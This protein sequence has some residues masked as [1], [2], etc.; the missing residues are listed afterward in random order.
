[1][2]YTPPA[3]HETDPEALRRFLEA[4]P[5]G[6]L[7]TGPPLWAT[8]LPLE[9]DFDA[10]HRPAAAWLHLAAANPQ[11]QALETAA[12]ALVVVLGPH[13]YISPTWYGHPNVP[14]WNYLAAHIS[15][16]IRPVT[17][18]DE[19]RQRLDALVAQYEGTAPG[20]YHLGQLPTGM[21]EKMLSGLR[22]FRLETTAT[23][24]ATK[25]SQ[26]RN[27]ADYQNIIAHLA[28]GTEDERAVATA[29]AALRTGAKNE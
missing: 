25:L 21:P 17:Q 29:M 9:W 19:M 26:N 6:T 5:F 20:A 23:H 12:D 2:L 16:R 27:E 18:P 10:Q 28:Q 3:F 7:V 24:F 4:H 11:A 22:M 13:A 14:T 8:H 1:M 15:V